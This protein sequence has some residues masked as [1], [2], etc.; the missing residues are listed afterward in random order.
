MLFAIIR[1]LQSVYN[2][3]QFFLYYFI[4]LFDEAVGGELLLEF[5]NVD[6]E[7]GVRNE[8]NLYFYLYIYK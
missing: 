8:M 7:E 4:E 3:Y 5:L 2:E 1:S 6:E